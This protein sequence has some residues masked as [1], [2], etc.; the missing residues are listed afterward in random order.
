[1]SRDDSAA[2]RRGRPTIRS[3]E[4]ENEIC[5]RIAHGES[6]ALICRDPSMPAESTVY[7]WLKSS[8]EAEGLRQMLERVDLEWEFR[9]F[10]REKFSRVRAVNICLRWLDSPTSILTLTITDYEEFAL[11][12]AKWSTHASFIVVAR[13]EMTFGTN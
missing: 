9:E 3:K 12:S 11:S 5:Y 2:R 7:R 10:L 4:V 6:V 1:M 8:N 13:Q